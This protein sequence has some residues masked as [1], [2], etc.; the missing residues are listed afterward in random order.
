MT[1]KN[2]NTPAPASDN[3]GKPTTV[4]VIAMAGW[5]FFALTATLLWLTV[6]KLQDI[7]GEAWRLTDRVAV[8]EAAY[9]KLERQLE[10]YEGMAAQR[11][12]FR[13]R[14]TAAKEVRQ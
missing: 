7:Y 4:V 3:Q 5:C 1:T 14:N 10:R 8:T 12:A 9:S 13:A 6:V 2:S 11:R